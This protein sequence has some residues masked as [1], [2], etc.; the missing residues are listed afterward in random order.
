MLSEKAVPL[1]PRRGDTV[2]PPPV[3]RAAPACLAPS[4][5]AFA[6]KVRASG[7]QEQSCAK[8]C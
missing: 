6:T 8:A 2:T 4:P 7:L 5:R 3:A 1:R